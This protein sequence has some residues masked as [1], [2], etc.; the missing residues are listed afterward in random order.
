MILN[1]ESNL[2]VELVAVEVVSA[3]VDAI[4][5]MTPPV[6]PVSFPGDVAAGG[7]F[8][9]PPGVEPPAG[10][11]NSMSNIII[12]LLVFHKIRNMSSKENRFSFV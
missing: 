12:P 8:E 4:E 7:N 2:A 6:S 10:D 3:P 1:N 9:L 11:F 5:L